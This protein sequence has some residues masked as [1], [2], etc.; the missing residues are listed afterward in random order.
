MNQFQI[1]K[2]FCSS[3]VYRNPSFSNEENINIFGKCANEDG[4]GHNY[5]V[6][7]HFQT[8]DEALIN[9][10]N[11]A[12]QKC[13]DALDHHHINLVTEEFAIGKQI[14]TTENLA[15]WFFQKISSK[16]PPSCRL[17]KITLFETAD[18]WATAE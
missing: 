17:K 12:L 15:K 4:H 16:L 14:P 18:L 5:R 13:V 11:V 2:S 10:A 9:V 3:H 7:A 6:V 1:A 8:D